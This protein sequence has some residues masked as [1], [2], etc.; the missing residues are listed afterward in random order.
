VVETR[1]AAS[2]SIV[3]ALS[4]KT[5]LLTGVTGFLAQVVFE[6]LLADFAETRILL[7]VRSQSSATS[8]ERV[9][10]LF[11]KPAFDGL[12]DRVG[13]QG[14]RRMLDERVDVI[15]ADFGVGP[16][17]V[18]TGV[19]VAMHSA[20]TVSFDPPIDEGFMTNLQ[21]AMNLYGGVI[22]S[23]SRP[24]LVHV[25]TAYVAGVQKGVIPEGPLEHR[26]DYRLELQLALEARHEVEAASRKPEM[27]NAFMALA[28]DEHSR[29]GPTTVAEGAEERRQKWVT[30]RLVEYGRTRARSLGWPDVYTFTKAMGERAVEEL[31]AEANLPLSIVR[32]SIIE[33]AYTHPFPG[34]IDGFKMADPIIRAYG[35]GQ[36]PEFPGIPEGIIDLI[37][38]DF[39]VNALLAVAANPPPPG[40]AAHYN[41]SSGSR[42]P[43]RFFELYEWVR[44][45]F[46]EHPL[47][48]R[49]RG[50]HK[51][52]NWEFPGNLKVERMLRRAE[53]LTDLAE[54]VVT[55][56]PK[57]K[58]MR[59]AVRRVDRDKA[60][61]DFVKRYSDLYGMYTETEVVYTDDRTLALFESL[62][63]EDKA[64]FP[65][66]AAMVDWKYYLQDVHS[67]AVTRSLRELSKRDRERPTVIIREREEPVLALFDMEGTIISS[68]VVESYV[69]ARLADLTPEEWPRELLSVFGRIPGYLQVDRRDRGDFLRTFFR[70]YE[71]ASVEGIDRLVA[72]HV[73]EFMLQK[74]SAPA[75]RRIREHRAAGHRTILITAAAEALVRPL[76]PLFDLVIGAELEVRDGRYTGFMSAPPLVG[77]ARSAWLRRYARLEGVDL[78]HS[79]AYADSYSDLPLLRAVG[80]PVAVSP[81]SSLYR[82]ARRRRWPIEEWGMTSGMPRVRFPRPAVRT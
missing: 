45:Y 40:E 78:R 6:R 12:R 38:V 60:R 14:L 49:G 18:P 28:R 50:E 4:G 11:R 76:S 39:V 82:Y 29:A 19:D 10:Y 77:E 37:P 62:N 51:V 71:G 20:A 48:E 56:L 61:V 5:L 79:Y 13:E 44:A 34:W 23:G 74:A 43:L 25:S 26:V 42:N 46:E 24:A 22:A 27:L 58:A 47:P 66:D 53:R 70:R 9:E 57:S 2:S 54:Q 75:I 64:N 35:L 8:R 63:P 52:P 16:P 32:P 68:N 31:A 1:P 15:D 7:L 81:D 21:G 69:W 65:F 3:E 59:D 72:D 36:I 41:V 30:K 55:H 17:D 67:P 73:A 80:N 33:S